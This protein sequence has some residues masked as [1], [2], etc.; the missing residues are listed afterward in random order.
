MLM[1][2]KHFKNDILSNGK[3]HV[4][5]INPAGECATNDLQESV[6]GWFEEIIE[7]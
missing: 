5:Y 6:L 3:P 1:S 2:E 4:T 7:T